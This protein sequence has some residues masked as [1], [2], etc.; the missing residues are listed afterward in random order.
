MSRASQVD[1]VTPRR[2][3]GAVALGATVALLCVA[4][5]AHA[6][7]ALQYRSTATGA[8]EVP[9]VV[10]GAEARIT[11]KV[12]QDRSSV[13][14]D[15]KITEPINDVVMAHLHR[16]VAG[17]NGPVAVWLYP[18][19]GPPGL[20]I[21]GTFEGRLAKDVIEPG[22]LCSP[23][24]ATYCVA[25]LPDWDR[26]LDDLAAG[27]IYVNVHTAARPAGEV[28]GQVHRHPGG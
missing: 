9:A 12:A 5:A 21:P 7:G 16:G 17:A 14:Y 11:L 28:R 24:G 25:G 26:F 18:H 19:A 3:K 13:R 23:P 20:P 4:G 2:S 8:E 27:G 15:L 1:D 22:D 6:A 10:T